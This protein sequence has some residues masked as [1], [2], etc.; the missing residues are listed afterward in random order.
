MIENN[1]LAILDYIHQFDS[2]FRKVDH[3]IV[4][5]SV[6]DL[7]RDSILLQQYES[8]QLEDFFQLS[9]T[10]EAYIFIVRVVYRITSGRFSSL[11]EEL[12]LFGVKTLDSNYG[13]LLIRPETF[14]DKV[15]DLFVHQD[16]DFRNFPEFSSKYFFI[17]DHPGNAEM[18]AKSSRLTLFEKFDDLLLEVSGNRMISKFPKPVNEA[19]FLSMIQIL[20]EI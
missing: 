20:R 4:P 5:E 6:S 12:Q 15:S 9:I 17:A 3:K 8:F 2:E 19:D 10:E 11:E 14:G 18:F 7:F 1:I 13:H 16:N